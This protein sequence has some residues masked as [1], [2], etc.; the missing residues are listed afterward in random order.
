LA[1]KP[2]PARFIVT[3]LTVYTVKTFWTRPKHD[4]VGRLLRPSSKIPEWRKDSFSSLPADHDGP[5]STKTSLG[6]SP[7]SSFTAP[8]HRT[9]LRGKRQQPGTLRCFSRGQRKCWRESPAAD[10]S[11]A[12]RPSRVLGMRQGSQTQCNAD[13]C[14]GTS[15]AQPSTGGRTSPMDPCPSPP[16]GP[17][18][19]NP[20]PQLNAHICGGEGRETSRGTAA[21][22]ASPSDQAQGY[23]R[24]WPFS[25]DGWSDGCRRAAQTCIKHLGEGRRR[26]PLRII[27]ALSSSSQDH[28][29]SGRE[30]QKWPHAPRADIRKCQRHGRAANCQCTQTGR[31]PLVH[32][33]CFF[34][35]L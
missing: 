10:A 21:G 28:R 22:T 4:V 15:G 23:H 17:L 8:A 1:H 25:R 3:V 12:H 27:H 14:R 2:L 31:E 13:G 32:I 11:S 34:A 6:S 7:L 19:S 26:A 5:F 29:L 16:S 30:A 24:A 18:Q 20:G 33:P 35:R 9:E